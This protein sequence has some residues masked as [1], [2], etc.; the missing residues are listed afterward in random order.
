MCCA[1]EIRQRKKTVIR[2]NVLRSFDSEKIL[3]R[4]KALTDHLEGFES[5]LIRSLLVNSDIFLNL[6][7]KGL[8]HKI[9]KKPLDA[10]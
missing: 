2:V 1:A 4:L 7:L 10:A 6:L 3:R 5:I 8:L 9:S